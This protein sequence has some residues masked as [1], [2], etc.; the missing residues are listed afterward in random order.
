MTDPTKPL[1]V[2][3]LLIAMLGCGM[4]RSRTVGTVVAVNRSDVDLRLNNGEI[5]HYNFWNYTSPDIREVVQVGQ[6]IELV[7]S[8]CDGD[9]GYF[10][11][12]KVVQP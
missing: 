8:E 3:L 5:H 12:I 7:C 1:C 4:T 9:M 10:G 6:R 2:F 11:S